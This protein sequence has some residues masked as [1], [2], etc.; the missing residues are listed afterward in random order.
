MMTYREKQFDIADKDYKEEDY[1]KSVKEINMALDF[2]SKI[3][4]QNKKITKKIEELIYKKKLANIN[5]QK[6]FEKIEQPKIIEQPEPVIKT[7]D[8]VITPEEKV[9][10]S[11][12]INEQDKEVYKPK[13]IRKRVK[14]PKKLH[15]KTK[16]TIHKKRKKYK[17]TLVTN[18]DLNQEIKRNWKILGRD[19]NGNKV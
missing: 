19:D 17:K 13:T 6:L 14:T 8:I 11:L 12:E 18:D 4:P 16:S 7:A 2:Y 3:K 10:P 1:S 5:E 9:T 15:K